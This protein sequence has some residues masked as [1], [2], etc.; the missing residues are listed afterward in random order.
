MAIRR[1]DN[2][3]TRLSLQQYNGQARDG[4]IVI[5]L[6][7]YNVY[8]GT[9][10]GTLVS[11]SNGSGNLANAIIGNLTVTGT[12]DLGLVGNV[13]IL[14]GNIGEVL[15]TDGTGNLSWVAG[16][17]GNYSNANV[18][19]YLPTYTGNLNSVNK[20]TTTGNVTVGTGAFFLGD[21]GLL[22]NVYSAANL[23]NDLPNYSG[24]LN[25][26]NNI[27]ATGNITAYDVSAAGSVFANALSVTNDSTFGGNVTA[28]GNVTGG[29]INTSGNVVATGTVTGGNLAT[30][31]NL[32]V[33]GTAGVGSLD[34]TLITGDSLTLQTTGL[35]Q[36]INLD[37]N[38]TGNINVNNSVINNVSTPVQAGDAANK[39]YVDGIASG[40]QI[41]QY[42]NATTSTVLPTYTYNNGAS[43]VGATITATASG[44]LSLSGVP[45]IT[46]QRVLIKDEIGANAA[47]NGIYEVTNAG[48]AGT[49]FVL[50]RAIDDDTP[51]LAYSAYTFDD[52][53]NTGWVCLNTAT[54][55]PIT[56]GTTPIEF[57]LFSQPTSY[58]AGLGL[59]LIGQ[60]FNVNPDNTTTAIN[61]SN[62]I[63]VKPGA[64]LINPNIGNATG[65]SMTVTGNITAGNTTTT[66]TTTTNV[67]VSNTS[68]VIGNSTVGGNLT[69]TGN[70][71][72]SNISVPGTIVSN[73]V[74]SNTSIVNGNS[75]VGGNSTV[76]GNSSVGGNLSVT[77]TSNLGQVGNVIILGGNP[78]EVL[79]TNG[80]GN[81]SWAPGGGG[82]SSYGNSNVSVYLAGNIPTDIIPLANAVQILGNVNNQWKEMW[83][84]DVYIN[85]IP[86]TAT[87]SQLTFNGVPVVTA[88][89]TEDIITSGNGQFN[90]VTATFGTFGQ[91]TGDGS[92][93]TNI[94]LANYAN[95]AGN[96]VNANQPNITTVGTLVNLTVAGNAQVGSNLAVTGNLAVGTSL[97]YDTTTNTLSIAGTA[98]VN[99]LETES[100]RGLSPAI[101]AIGV[102]GGISLQTNGTGNVNVNGAIISSVATPI[103]PNDAANKAYVDAI[104][105]GLSINPSVQL[106][107]DAPLPAYTYNNGTSGVGATISIVMPDANPLLIEGQPAL[108]GYRVLIKNEI[109]ANQPYNGIYSVGYTSATLGGITTYTAELTRTTDFDQS[110]E[111]P[112]AFVFDEYA[113]NGWVCTNVEPPPITVG[114]TPIIWTQFSRAGQYA[115]GIGLSQ[116][117]TDFNVNTDGITVA[118]NAS[119]ELEVPPNAQFVTPNIGSATGSNLTVTGNIGAANITATGLLTASE[120]NLGPI[121]NITVLGGTSGQAITTDGAGNLSFVTIPAGYGNSDVSVYLDGNI[122]TNIVPLSNAAQNLGSA[123]NQW[124]NMWVGGT[125]QFVNLN[126]ANITITNSI[127]GNGRGLSNIAGANI[128]GAVANA[129]YAAYAG[130]VVNA[131]QSNITTV[132]TLTGLTVGGTAQ[133]SGNLSVGT[134]FQLDSANGNLS[135][136]GVA[137]V[138]QLNTESIRGLSPAIT[139]TGVNGGISLQTNGTGNVDVNGTNIVNM[140]DPVNPQ[141]AAT[142]AY[143]DAVASGL[144]LKNAVQLASNTP[145]PAYTYNNGAS[146]VGATINLVMPDANP[147]LIEGQPALT[148]YR[149]LIKDEIGA[150]QPYNGIYSVNYSSSSITAGGITITTYFATLTRTT[151]CNQPTEFYSAFVFDQYSGN[152]WVCTNLNANP[153]TIGTTPIT[154]TQ[155]SQSGQYF[156]GSGLEL[157]S[158]TF[159]V[160]VDGSTVA[161]NGTNEL[162]IPP[163]APLITPNIGNATGSSL[164]VTGNLSSANITAT[165]LLT[166][167][168]S[169]LGQVGNITILGGSDGQVLTTDG[170]GNLSWTTGAANVVA[171]PAM[172]FVAPINGNNQAFS[173]VFLGQYET[174]ADLTVFYNGA[175]L[176]DFY[177]LS[178]STLTV[179]I[180]LTTGDSIDV[181][182]QFANTTTVYPQFV[183][184][185]SVYFVAPTTGNNQSFINTTLSNYGSAADLTVFYNGTLLEEQYYSL[186]GD[187]LTVNT[188]LRAGDTIDIPR[189][190]AGNVGTVP[191]TYGNS[192]VLAYLSS[193][194]YAGDVIPAGNNIHSLGNV[195]NQWKDLWVSSSTIYINSIPIG[196]NAANVLTVNGANVVTT[197]PNG[198]TS[199][200]GVLKVDGNIIAN[201]GYFFLGDG[202]L[203]SNISGTGSYSNANVANYLPTYTGNLDNVDIIVASGN[204]T[205]ANVD[206][207]PGGT[208][209]F[210]SGGNMYS[211]PSGGLAGTVTVNGVNDRGISLTAGG[212]T[213]GSSYSQ[214]QWVQDINTY[215]P[216]SPAGSITNWVYVQNDG[217]Y[218]ENFDLLNASGYNYTWKF[219]T[220]GVL[221]A[222]GDITT[223]GNIT[224]G[225]F[226]GDGGLLSNIAAGSD[227]SNANV[228]N[229]L[230][231]Y[232]GNLDSVGN[233]TTTTIT[234]TESANLGDVGNVYVGGGNSGEVLTTDGSGSL[235]WSVVGLYTVPPVYITAVAAGNNQTFSNTILASYNS[236]TEMTVFYNGAL[237]ENTYYTLVGDTIT[238]NIPLA[239]GDGID[240]VTT[241]ASN[242]NSIVSSGY[243]NSNVAAYLPQ[244][245]GNLA[246]LAGDVTTTANVTAAKVSLGTGNL[247]LVGNVISS[248]A[249]TITIDPLGDGTGAGN[250]VVQGN[251]QVA[252]TLTFNNVVNATTDDLQWIAANNAINPAAASGGGLSVGPLGA[253]ASFIYNSGLNVWQSSLP[254]IAN[255]GVNANGALSGATT[256]SFSGDVTAA[257]FIGDGSLLTNLPISPT[258]K[259]FNGTSNVEIAT[260]NGNITMSVDGNSVG[261]ITATRLAIGQDSGA[262]S[263]GANAVAIGLLAG[264]T[265][266]GSAAIAIGSHA[267]QLNQPANSIMLNASD[268]ALNGTNSGFYVNPVRNDTGNTTNSIF[269]NPTTKEITYSTVAAAI[270]SNIANGTS[271]VSIAAANGN[272]DFAVNGVKTGTISANSIAVGY[273]A[274]KTSQGANSVAIGSYAGF[275]AQGY[276]SV[277]IGDGAGQTNQGQTSI[278]IG[279][280]GATNQ[281]ANA[282]AIGT[283]SAM[284]SQGTNSVAIGTQSGGVNQAANSVAIGAY[285]QSSAGAVVLNATGASLLGDNA[286]FYVNPVRNDLANTAQVVTYNTTSKELTYANT[287]SVA[288][289]ITAGN[290]I[291]TG[292]VV[293]TN[294]GNVA[295]INLNG[296][297]SRFLS[298]A[299]TWQTAS[300]S[301][302][303]NITKLHQGAGYAAILLVADGRLFC[304]KGTGN[305][306]A[307][308]AALYKSKD[309]RTQAGIDNCYEITFPNETVGTIVDAGSYGISAYALF[310][311]GN[312]Y[313]WGYNL[314][315]QLGLGNTTDTFLPT[316][317]NTNVV[318]VFT[319][320]SQ[321]ALV[322]IQRLVIEKNDNTFWG[323]GHDAQYQ[324][325][326]G[327]ITAKTS[328]TQ[329]P[330]I[331]SGSTVWNLGG[332]LGCLVVQ[333]GS[334]NSIW[335]SGWNGTGALGIGSTTQPTVGT[336]APLWQAGDLT[337]TIQSAHLGSPYNSND[338]R[339][340][341]QNLA[342]LMN[343]GTQSRLVAA[344]TNNWGSLGTGGTT[345]S[346]VPVVPL[347]SSG[348]TNTDIDR[349]ISTGPAPMTMYVLM[350]NK[351][352]YTY[353]YN[354]YGQC[355]NGGTTQIGTPFKLTTDVLDMMGDTQGFNVLGFFSQSPLI[356]KSTGWFSCGYGSYSQ[357]GNGDTDQN[358][359]TL[360][361][362]LVPK[363]T[364]FKFV[365]SYGFNEGQTRI[366]IDTDNT[367]WAWGYNGQ[368]SIDP[369]QT[370]WDFPVPV[371]FTPN[372]LKK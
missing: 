366:A 89:G 369:D 141:D 127:S 218:I 266:Q 290:L 25:N 85:S 43:G 28:A 41:K 337:M 90:R 213:P 264:E 142:K 231:T 314:Y 232:S 307:W 163:N 197:S 154:W 310:A 300:S 118:V 274:G 158:S 259:I 183:A 44:A 192:N 135:L 115:P 71:T 324:L 72:I 316:L 59:N 182:R 257:Q 16:G 160:L 138:N 102:N 193:G 159:N 78:G 184:I 224:A 108:S 272:I 112:S 312:L 33:V 63:G 113:G 301:L 355:G 140:L 340:N 269:Y 40:L 325:G 38:G 24:N 69:V 124:N 346:T 318:R 114:T 139:A 167:S 303:R 105:S 344:G 360:K 111:I 328:W 248:T 331:T 136:Q 188:I 262:T 270:S 96:V 200:E 18:A 121:G 333:Q 23:A 196:I 162:S 42:V 353:G 129:N 130:N 181:I 339:T 37:P 19:N 77:G 15:T 289:N 12:T 347:Q 98:N 97:T 104:A 210:A 229:Y 205:A 81:L 171:I 277:A 126:A 57:T 22:S 255:G 62:Q 168:E 308:Y 149:V 2:K 198:T 29:N 1:D 317:S 364:M 101:T 187:T 286:G 123:A 283:F 263:Q 91:I 201:T 370:S 350:T 95:Y 371:S 88:S 236:N 172:Y 251:M 246:N 292:N 170:T 26:V 195:T 329:L 203:L 66:G 239:V 241:I 10:N 326:L 281:Q 93:I 256:G 164:T 21:G 363:D 53:S 54:N 137:N 86:L 122:P 288:G 45:V 165:G 282:I 9:A 49:P 342:L 145:L 311:N 202:G 119:N 83:A 243:G 206:V 322:T 4:E 166:A 3:Y 92:G 161:I 361:R 7:T 319:H 74:V 204:V 219:G 146:G 34:T 356:L 32:T 30:S 55:N 132:G 169:D 291:A 341:L 359:T 223:P 336:A 365:S 349:V 35:N 116:T 235:S 76:A 228:A 94:G 155:F 220:D 48:S 268:T 275:S 67:I 212:T 242:V 215:D 20:V 214:I 207:I 221:S 298:G 107:T 294:I 75:T 179:N 305:G 284:T 338:A 296:D 6:D 186:T 278:A 297:S 177:T 237:L 106:A 209:S 27:S 52:Y 173:N 36:G 147:L 153:I 100:V 110:A 180:P 230:P 152:G 31:G 150:N 273:E 299:G 157:T 80:S 103:N 315:G 362:L 174:T 68:T 178:G 304:M 189:Q 351:D 8:V 131:N 99:Q 240:V 194:L 250:V 128:V 352:L 334:D 11:V 287:I 245:T 267:G 84:E 39:A 323:C 234:V 208:V 56:F 133:V 313:T 372:A 306:G 252:G 280:A 225:F 335:V 46:G 321:D 5:D 249:D 144:E 357:I 276:R 216:Y 367:V 82:G 60:Q 226:I 47:Y 70:A 17:G 191:S 117:G 199:T 295:A 293:A 73:T 190:L 156:A 64:Q 285:A 151:D 175:L 348:M 227:Y 247:Q 176:D 238:V 358:N 258:D 58:I 125:G 79:T 233:I 211:I 50:T 354:S 134:R 261:T 14:G 343:N 345:N 320:P 217:T 61:G 302:S 332:D 330:W 309:T 222:A 51:A 143:V 368:G 265:N 253:Y 65:T 279:Y 109:G 260:V 87:G 185:P 120:S 244:Y 254:I 327:T 13:R 271:N 148:G